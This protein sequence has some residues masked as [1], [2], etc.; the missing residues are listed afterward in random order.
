[1][2]LEGGSDDH[3]SCTMCLEPSSGAVALSHPASARH[4][5]KVSDL[6]HWGSYLIYHVNEGLS[7]A[8]SKPPNGFSFVAVGKGVRDQ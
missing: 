1:M 6:N 5:R 3:I 8:S 7:I 4:E 2:I